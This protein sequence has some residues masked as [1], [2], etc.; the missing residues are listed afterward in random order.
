[1]KNKV[2]YLQ[3]FDFGGGKIGFRLTKPNEKRQKYSIWEIS[4]GNFFCDKYG[5]GKKF[6]VGDAVLPVFWKSEVPTNFVCIY[7]RGFLTKI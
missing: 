7:C 5:C 1:M 2:K 6:K 3:Q 4:E